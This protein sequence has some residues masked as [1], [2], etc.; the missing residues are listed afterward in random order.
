MNKY[1]DIIGRINYGLF[2]TVV[3]LL[4]FPQTPLRYAFVFWFI[5]WCMELRWLRKPSLFSHSS[6]GFKIVL[7]FMMFGLWYASKALSGLWAPD[8]AAW[9]WQM[10]RYLTFVLLI[11]VG[12]WGFNPYYKWR[13]IGKVLVSSCVVALPLYI[14][15]MTVIYYHPELVPYSILT[16]PWVQH[17]NWWTFLAE[18]I[19]HFKHRLFLC[20]VELL[21][22]MVAFQL[23]YKRLKLLIP[24]LLVMLSSIP[25][26][27]SRQSVLTAIAMLAVGIVYALPRTYRWRYGLGII[28][29]GM[30]V[31]VGVFKTHPRLKQVQ[32]QD[33]K[34]MRDMSYNHDIR[35]NIW[36][37]ALQHPSDYIAYGL[38]AGQSETYLTKRYNDVKFDY[39]AARQYH[40]HNQY[41]EELMEI[42]IPGLI[43]FFLAWLSVPLCAQKKGRLTA[44][45]F[46][47][48]FGFNMFTDC[49]F[50]K[51]CGI[52]LWAVGLILIFLQSNAE[53][54]EQT[55]GDTETH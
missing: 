40:A 28:L 35:F 33:V 44:I 2:L 55:A 29:I 5:T 6:S 7:P 50:G 11:P 53:S 21:G 24:I 1:R 46:I 19:S 42:G 27:G 20:S 41:L 36:G 25:L 8:H 49:M 31:G 14:T 48:L 51:F 16:E 10:E 22:A 37:A 15:W 54:E 34:E 18:N 47:T 13:Q 32:V 17:E 52:A 38:G 45:L 43:L 4:P 30:L 23:Y 9:S 39:Y 26:T 12:I 3:M